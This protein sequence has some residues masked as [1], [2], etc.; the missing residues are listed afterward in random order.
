MV[1]MKEEEGLFLCGHSPP[2]RS[3]LNLQ[4]CCAGVKV[5]SGIGALRF[6]RRVYSPHLYKPCLRPRGGSPYRGPPSSGDVFPSN[7]S[8]LSAFVSCPF[9]RSADRVYAPFIFTSV[10]RFVALARANTSP[11]M[12]SPSFIFFLSGDGRGRRLFA[13]S[14]PSLFQPVSFP[15]QDP[16]HKL[17][18]SPSNLEKKFLLALS[19]FTLPSSCCGV[20][21]PTFFFPGYPDSDQSHHTPVHNRVDISS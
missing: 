3:S 17:V 4:F 16:Q 20:Y 18:G 13:M 8:T 14:Q 15:P 1:G 9:S 21:F 6:L 12:V 5:F 10:W 7:D 19:A 2:S 11:C